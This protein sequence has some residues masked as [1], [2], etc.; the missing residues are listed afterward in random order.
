MY[1]NRLS[2]RYLYIYFKEKKEQNVGKAT[3]LLLRQTITT[4]CFHFSNAINV[5]TVL[6]CT[7]C[8]CSFF[9]YVKV[10]SVCSILTMNCV[11]YFSQL[12]LRM[13]LW[14][15][16]FLTA[17]AMVAVFK[18]STTWAM[19]LLQLILLICF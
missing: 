4:Q 9:S 17:S 2:T 5:A 11:V 12:R 6:F 13:Y 10:K 16:D 1:H 19:Q 8:L 15:M 7:P 14:F 18:C 3:R